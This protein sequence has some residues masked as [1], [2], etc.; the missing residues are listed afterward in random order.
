MKPLAGLNILDFSTLLPGPWAT[1]QLQS[2]GAQVTRIESP[3]HPDL[4]RAY[5][6]TFAQL[7]GEKNTLVLDL[8]DS[9]SIATIKQQLRD[10]D[11]LLEQF[12]PGVMQRLGLGYDALK[13]EY[14]QLIYCSL[15]GYGQTGPLAMQAGHDINYQALAGLASYNGAATPVTTA[16]QIG[17][18]AGGSYP[19]MVAIL[20]AVIE[21]QQTGFGQHIDIAMA[22]GA[23]ALNTLTA[24]EVLAGQ[25]NPKA[26]G[27]LL[28]G[29]SF[30][31]YYETADQ[32]WLAVGAL[33]PKFFN[34]LCQALG[35]PEW[36]SRFADY[37]DANQQSLKS[38]LRALFLQRTLQVWLS[39][40][41]DECCVTPVLNLADALRHPQFVERGMV[42]VDDQGKRY[43]NVPIRFHAEQ[44]STG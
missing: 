14:P 44:D 33:E 39:V 2:M 34:A 43:L 17:D 35:K 9:T 1:A 32:Q 6:N 23:L 10:V 11:I 19:A 29:G 25:P 20:A 22:D 5:P 13:A 8:K 21:R 28:N 16:V 24:P 36:V 41:N 7:N 18:I 38:D 31:D 30:Y 26:R 40:L 15:T 37:S 3:T 27:N 42:C 4:L 12:R